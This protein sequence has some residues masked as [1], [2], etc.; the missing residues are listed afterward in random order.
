MRLQY[1]FLLLVLLA[2]CN[3]QAGPTMTPFVPT[4]TP[5]GP[6]VPTRIPPTLTPTLEP[7]PTASA[8]ATP[9]PTSTAT[10]TPTLTHTPEPSATATATETFTPSPTPAEDQINYGEEKIAVIDDTNPLYRYQFSAAAGDQITIN[11]Q[12]TSGDL[13]SFLRLLDATEREIAIN[14]DASNATRDATLTD[15]ILPTDGVYTIIASR[16]GDEFGTTSG[17]FTLSVEQST[18]TA[19]VVAQN[20][21]YNETITGT[22][23]NTLYETRYSFEAS[24]GDTL[25]IDLEAATAGLD[26]FLRLLDEAGDE[27]A[28]NDDRSPR[29]RDAQISNFEVPQGGTYTIIATRYNGENG[30]TSGDYMLTLTLDSAASA[31]E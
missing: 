26:P 3:P 30:S 2:A 15:I 21:A 13:D 4:D 12:A 18:L 14:D 20:I 27:I 24:A 31:G 8:T 7:S 9:E 5:Q 19:P 1:V 11:L 17:E 22:I 29:T 16:L 10:S 23:S 6:V 28:S 25:T